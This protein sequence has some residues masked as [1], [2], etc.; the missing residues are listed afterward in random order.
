[1]KF[2]IR[3]A[4][5]DYWR[6]PRSGRG[7]FRNCVGGTEYRTEWGGVFLRIDLRLLG[8]PDAAGALMVRAAAHQVDP[9][10]YLTF[11]AVVDPEHPI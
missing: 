1:M 4:I 2:R 11:L 9:D 6:H 5:S 7:Y 10:D 8:E 3:R